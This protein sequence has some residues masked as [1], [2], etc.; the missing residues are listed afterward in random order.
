M[1]DSM[2][3]AGFTSVV[4]IFKQHWTIRFPLFHD[5]YHHHSPRPVYSGLNFG[6]PSRHIAASDIWYISPS[7]LPWRTSRSFSGSMFALSTVRPVNFLPFLS[8]FLFLVLLLAS[9]FR[10]VSLSGRNQNSHLLHQR[11]RVVAHIPG[12]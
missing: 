2:S 12:F 11:L 7:T 10:L 9:S 6:V 1:G 8:I 4:I 3:W 5:T